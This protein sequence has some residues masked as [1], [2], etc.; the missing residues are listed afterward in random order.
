MK[1]LA[2]LL[3]IL[4]SF[5][6]Y[7]QK[8]DSTRT[9]YKIIR[10]GMIEH[11]TELKS[12]RYIKNG[13][14]EIKLGRNI[15]ASGLY[16]NGQ[17]YGRWRFFNGPDSVEQIYNYT[18]KKLEYNKKAKNITCEID[19]AKVGDR[20]IQP[21]K[22]GGF[23]SSLRLLIKEFAP[24]KE[25]RAHPGVHSVF[26]IFYINKEGKL[27]KYEAETVGNN[28]KLSEIIPLSKFHPDELDFTPAYLN[29]KPASSR[30]IF[31]SKLTVE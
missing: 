4:I 22:I 5:L 30:L 28:L 14:S 15:V 12:K 13:E 16:K 2:S 3:L 8:S 25:F 19:A 23:Y 18:T 10:G 27:I 31:E 20:I 26:L 29:G 7:A 17:R 11:S 24:S 1:T 21:A 6:T 9:H